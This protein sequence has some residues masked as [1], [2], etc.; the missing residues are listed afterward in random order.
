MGYGCHVVDRL[1]ECGFV[2]ARWARR[3]A[4]LSDELQRRRT[5]LII[6]G[7]RLEVG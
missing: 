2:R 3:A 6:G 7:G 4:Q 1:I 5:N